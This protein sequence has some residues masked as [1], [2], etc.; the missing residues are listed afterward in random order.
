MSTNIFA[1]LGE[2]GEAPA[3]PVAAKSAAA[4][5]KKPAGKNNA[6]A[7]SGGNSSNNNNNSR[8]GPREGGRGGGKGGGRGGR[9]AYEASDDQSFGNGG[10]GAGAGRGRGGNRPRRDGDGESRPRR[11]YDRH[12]S[13]SGHGRDGEKRGAHGKGNWGAE[14]DNA[15]AEKK[16]DAEAEEPAVEE[17]P[18]EPDTELTMSEFYAQQEAERAKLNAERKAAAAIDNSKIKNAVARTKDDEDEY[19]SMV[20]GAGKKERNRDRT[21]AK[22]LTGG[23]RAPAPTSDRYDRPKGGKG[24][25]G[26]GGK[27]D[28]GGKGGSGK[29]MNAKIDDASAFPTLGGKK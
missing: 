28:F 5:T 11:E 26:K 22:T 17:E 13:R 2:D 12:V 18:E 7:K 23:F 3:A 25:G 1:L 10:R 6:P 15:N 4:D 29:G 21:G 16:E 9:P 19:S 20:K 27:G 8:G 14:G 24:K